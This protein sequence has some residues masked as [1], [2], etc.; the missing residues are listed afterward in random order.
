ML[1]SVKLAQSPT[2]QILRLAELSTSLAQIFVGR[3]PATRASREP[4]L[5]S[6]E[7]IIHYDIKAAF[8]N[9]HQPLSSDS[10]RS[11][12]EAWSEASVRRPSFTPDSSQLHR[13]PEEDAKI[14]RAHLLSNPKYLE[15][16]PISP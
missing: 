3:Q 16:L 4:A 9:G 15:Q 1:S 11:E 8:L 5:C 6:G 10:R 12:K 2:N 7:L 13:D 14:L